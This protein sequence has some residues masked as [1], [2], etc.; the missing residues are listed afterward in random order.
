MT[1]STIIPAKPRKRRKARPVAAPASLTLV[2]VAFDPVAHR[3]DLTF[4]RA[5][6]VAAMDATRVV[7]DDSDDGL[8]WRGSGTP[9]LPSPEVVRVTLTNLGLYSV[10][11][12]L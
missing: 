8:R 10:P 12:T 11:V 1:P 4:D 2:A 5:V 9:T 7:V 3:I 6:N